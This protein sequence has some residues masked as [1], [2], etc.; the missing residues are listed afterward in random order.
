ME[1]KD[2]E[3]ESDHAEDWPPSPADDI[4]ECLEKMEEWNTTVENEA[5]E[6]MFTGGPR[7]TRGKASS[8]IARKVKIEPRDDSPE[9]NESQPI[10]PLQSTKVEEE[11]SLEADYTVDDAKDEQSDLSDGCDGPN[12]DILAQDRQLMGPSAV[13]LD[14]AEDEGVPIAGE[15][16]RRHVIMEGSGRWIIAE[17]MVNSLYKVAKEKVKDVFRELIRARPSKVKLEEKG[18]AGVHMDSVSPRTL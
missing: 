2:S 18:D 5:D 8:V 15:H 14:N 3:E 10:L 11:E 17:K 13:C 12:D 7:K 6:S 4:Q 9:P 16:F 1:R